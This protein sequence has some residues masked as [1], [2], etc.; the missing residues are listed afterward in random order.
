MLQV[1][2]ALNYFNVQAQNSMIVEE[3][4]GQMIYK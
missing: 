2:A 4:K 1:F 3:K